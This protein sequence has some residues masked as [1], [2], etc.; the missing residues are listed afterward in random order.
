MEIRKTTQ[1][2]VVGLQYGNKKNN[3]VNSGGVT[4]WKQEKT[5]QAGRLWDDAQLIPLLQEQNF[6]WRGLAIRYS[7]DI[8]YYM[9]FVLSIVMNRWEHPGPFKPKRESFWSTSFSSQSPHVISSQAVTPLR[10]TA[11][12][13]LLLYKALVLQRYTFLFLML[14]TIQRWTN[15]KACGH[16]EWVVPPSPS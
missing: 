1:L 13:L 9:A 10:S 6:D 14:L 4:I 12:W 7:S 16:F 5:T 15:D 3:T 8:S 2:T 11:Y